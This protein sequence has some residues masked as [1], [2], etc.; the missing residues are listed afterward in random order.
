MPTLCPF[1]ADITAMIDQD[2][3]EKYINHRVVQILMHRQAS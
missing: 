2:S 1:F 3:T